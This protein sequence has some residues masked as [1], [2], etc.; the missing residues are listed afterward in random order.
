MDTTVVTALS[1]KK[2][3]P[4][5]GG[6]PLPEKEIECR[7][8]ALRRW[9]I[10]EGK[11]LNKAYEFK[12]FAEAMEFVNKVAG[13]AESECHHPDIYIFYNRVELKLWT[14]AVGGLTENDFIIAAKIDEIHL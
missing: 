9:K 12:D 1:Q 7:F 14:H 4:C 13:I 3:I 10:E 6:E 11:R 2:C 5:E 8:S